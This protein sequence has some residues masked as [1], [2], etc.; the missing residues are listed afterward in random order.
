MRNPALC[1]ECSGSGKRRHSH[2]QPYPCPDCNGTGVAVVAEPALDRRAPDLVQLLLREG[3]E[4]L[5]RARELLQLGAA[6]DQIILAQ[7]LHSAGESF[8][9]AA[10]EIA[11]RARTAP[12][13]SPGAGSRAAMRWVP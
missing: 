13:G 12:R 3:D 2:G 6:A 8:I 9:E 4:A 7:E 5:T 10:G 1:R 11:L